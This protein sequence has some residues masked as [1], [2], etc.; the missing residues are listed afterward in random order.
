MFYSHQLFSG[1]D[2]QFSKGPVGG[3]SAPPGF[4][5][6]SFSRARSQQKLEVGLLG[7][8]DQ[9]GEELATP[10]LVL[11]TA[12]TGPSWQLLACG[13]VSLRCTGPGNRRRFRPSR[14]GVGVNPTPVAPLPLGIPRRSR[15]HRLL[16]L[17][18]YVHSAKLSAWVVR[19]CH[20]RA[21]C[22]PSSSEV[23]EGGYSCGIECREQPNALR[24]ARAPVRWWFLLNNR[25]DAFFKLAVLP[26][27][28]VA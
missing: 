11:A 28:L 24:W 16:F 6:H 21:I 13:G 7:C 17:D 1:F 9:A 26:K 25:S 2:R 4:Q 14:W 23:D 27:F 19:Q 12:A 15:G 18:S 5:L 3:W 10:G 20:W 8:D 22:G